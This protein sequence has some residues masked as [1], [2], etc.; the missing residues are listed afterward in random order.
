MS[1]II[2][3]SVDTRWC[4]TSFTPS[5]AAVPYR[6]RTSSC[7]SL[8]SPG[9]AGHRSHPRPQQ[10]RTAVGPPHVYLCAHQVALDIVHTLVR[11]SPVP[12]SDRLMYI[13]VVTRWRWTSFTPSS[14]AVLY[15]CRTSS[16]VSLWSPGGAGH[17]SHPRP[18]QSRTA[19]GPHVYLCGHQVAL[20]IVHT[21]VRSSPVPLS[22][23]LM[24][25]SVV[26]MWSPGG[27]GHRS[28]PRPQQSRTAV[29]P[30]HVYL[31]GHQ[32]ALDIVHTLVRRSPV[33]LSDLLMCISVVTRWRW[34]SF[35]PSSAAV[36]YRCRTSCISLWSPGGAGHRSHPRP[37][38]SR[39]AVGPH[40][41]LCSHQV[42]LDIVH[43]LVRSSPVPLSDLLMYISVVTRWR[44]TSFTPSSAAV[45]YR[46]RI[47]SCVSLWS[48]G[49]VGHRSH[50]RPQQSRTAVG[51][52]HVY[53]CAHQV[54]LDIVHTL[55][56]SSPVPLSDLMYISVVTRWRWTSFT[57]SSAA[58]L[59]RC[60]TSSCISLWSPCGHQ[61]A[62]DI[63]HTLVR[64]SPVPLSDR[65]M[66][67]SVVTRWRWTS[68]TPS[69][70]AVLYRCRTSSCVS[71]WSPGGAGHRSHPRPQQSRTA[72]GP[73]VYLC[74]HQVA[75]DIVHTLVRSSPVP[76]S[77]LM[78]ISVVTRWR[79]TSFTPSSAA[80][81]YRC[82]TSSC[83]SLWSPGGAGH[84]SHP[85]PQ[86]SRTAVGSPHVYLCG[87][88][89]AL[90]IVHTLV[91]SS[92]VPLS[93]LL[94]CISVLTRWRWTSFTPSSAAV[95]YRCRTSSCISLCSPGGAGHRS[96]PR[97]QQSRPAVGPPHVYLCGHQVALDIVHTLV[98]SS[99]VPLSDLLMCISV[100]TRWRWTSFTP[101]SAAVPYRCRTSSCARRSLRRCSAFRKQRITPSCR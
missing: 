44:W 43:T 24:Y 91:R 72:V 33:P 53:L 57:P 85:R 38:Q 25:I 16:C 92:P 7:V 60:R 55:V 79:W 34:T 99:P 45:P 97:P 39:T 66:Y 64:S 88:Q 90:D 87:H 93:D 5:S 17:R 75:L 83:I 46:C 20:D 19:V 94:M 29:G 2:F 63:V 48:P 31:C 51:P 40:V 84:R 35:T 65:L 50:P 22:D 4:W 10:S 26:T 27:A 81:L 1:L 58:V 41:Y 69:S 13:S 12:L 49:G 62:L 61:V 15:R 80:V 36:P 56:R 3:T 42:A 8:C 68:F 96:H 59:Y 28:H 18:Q 70:A 95:P 76:L 11:S 30:P 77:D 54:A 86:Q 82:R 52:P 37:Q 89:V 78:Y 14:A 47:S 9:G 100:L 23:L 6:C 101:S 71:L 21:L 98:R 32:V 73:H 67:I 74:G